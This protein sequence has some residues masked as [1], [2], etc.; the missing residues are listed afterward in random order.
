MDHGTDNDL[1]YIINGLTY[2][3]NHVRENSVSMMGKERTIESTTKTMC[4]QHR[5][6]SSLII[7]F[8]LLII[9]VFHSSH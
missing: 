3:N 1:L 4:Q 6:K 5:E 8:H 9:S 2:L 7:P